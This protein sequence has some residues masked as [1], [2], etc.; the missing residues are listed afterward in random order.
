ML[1]L[2]IGLLVGS[3]VLPPAAVGAGAEGRGFRYGLVTGVHGNAQQSETVYIVDD[4]NELILIYE[5]NAR[6][7]EL[8]ARNA[9]DLRGDASKFIKLRARE[10]EIKD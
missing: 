3:V 1:T 8:T 6:S 5:Y 4:L 7:R 10:K 2:A 9:V